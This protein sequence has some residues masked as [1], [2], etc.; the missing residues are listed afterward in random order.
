MALVSLRVKSHQGHLV[1]VGVGN[2]SKKG[3]TV[4]PKRLYYLCTQPMPETHA[5]IS[6]HFERC[7]SGLLALKRGQGKIRLFVDN[8]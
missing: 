8:S 5:L 1:Q 3:C 7:C 2:V 4:Y 6:E